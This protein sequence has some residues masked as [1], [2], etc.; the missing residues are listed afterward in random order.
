MRAGTK[1]TGA[2]AHLDLV[3]LVANHE[4]PQ[5]EGDSTVGVIGRAIP[6]ECFTSS[7]QGRNGARF[8]QE[9]LDCLQ[10]ERQALRVK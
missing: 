1:T 9:G 7:H 4:A 5:A 10:A 3:W 2:A 6:G 8:H